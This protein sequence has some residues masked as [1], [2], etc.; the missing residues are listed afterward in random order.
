MTIETVPLPKPHNLVAEVARTLLYAVAIVMLVRA[1]LWQPFSIP[2]SSMAETLLPGDYVGVS[3]YAYGY[4][5]FSLP[6][7]LDLFSGRIWAAEPE[8][9]DVVVFK[10]PR[11]NATDYIKRVIGLPGDRI[12]IR[13]GVLHINGAPVK[14]EPLGE[15]D[16]EAANAPP[17]HGKRYRETLPGGRSYTILDK[18]EASAGDNTGEYVVPP[19][20]CFVMGDNRDDS[21]DSRFA[22]QGS[23][24]A[25]IADKD[26]VGFVPFDNLVGRA[27]T[28]F[29][30]ADGSAGFLEVWNWPAAIRWDRLFGSIR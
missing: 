4:S 30:S 9:G 19:G 13:H 23:G 1:F 28:I 25:F 12:Q 11:D 17:L 10:L 16:V 18:F 5:R 24:G 29:F 21:T 8:R 14:L 27:D 2:S 3:K 20:Y 26:G 7:G 15:V 6:G 22:P